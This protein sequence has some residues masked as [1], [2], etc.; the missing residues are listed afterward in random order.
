[1]ISNL[2]KLILSI[3]LKKKKKLL[4]VFP[5]KHDAHYFMW[6][7]SH[8]MMHNGKTLVHLNCSKKSYSILEN[9]HHI[10]IK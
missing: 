4:I 10:T 6:K 8:T 7:V 9:E 3:F 1:M 5:R 2:P